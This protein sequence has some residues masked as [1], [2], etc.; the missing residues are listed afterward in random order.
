MWNI[1]SIS[2]KSFLSKKYGIK[3]ECDFYKKYT[4]QKYNQ[5]MIFQKS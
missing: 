4:K 3:K 2:L 5:S 1:K